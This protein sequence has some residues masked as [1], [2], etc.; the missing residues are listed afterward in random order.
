M[1]SA[2]SM[3]RL[4]LIRHANADWKDFSMDDFE[5]PLNPRG[6]REAEALGK[7]LMKNEL[8]PDLLLASAARR[9]KQTAEILARML[10]LP[11]RRVQF[12]EPLYL[13]RPEAILELAQTT[14]STVPHLAIV[15]H[16][17]GI[18]ELAR[19]LAPEDAQIAE[20]A[21]GSACTLTFAVQSWSEVVL[22]A[23][24][25]MCYELP[26]KLFKR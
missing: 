14:G 20:L 6:T 22:G 24:H 2:D 10:S 7:L 16:N 23:S 5:R 19:G 15:G 1:G 12:A 4:T 8:V 9:A 18:S 11:A 17:P 21:T 13:A 25:V 3:L 26:V